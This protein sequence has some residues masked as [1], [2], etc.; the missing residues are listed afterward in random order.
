M[1]IQV[2]DISRNGEVVIRNYTYQRRVE[3][4]L[5]DILALIEE[6]KEQLRSI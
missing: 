1:K 4:Q 6:T 3:R 5:N 2:K